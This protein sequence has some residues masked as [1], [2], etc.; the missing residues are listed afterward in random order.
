MHKST[1]QSNL[2]SGRLKIHRSNTSKRF[3][4]DFANVANTE[5]AQ[6]GLLHELDRLNKRIMPKRKFA[7]SPEPV[8]GTRFFRNYKR[9]LFLAEKSKPRVSS[10]LSPISDRSK[11][12]TS[13][14]LLKN[15]KSLTS[16]MLAM[17]SEKYKQSEEEAKKML[18]SEEVIQQNGYLNKRYIKRLNQVVSASMPSS[19][20]KRSPS[21]TVRL[22]ISPFV[23]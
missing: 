1:T 20:N 6:M 22:K 21:K 4:F 7:T 23:L 2:L 14:D 11:F 13:L 8:E 10:P 15:L 18:V 5:T 12:V 3:S 9:K 17:R 19:P 16:G